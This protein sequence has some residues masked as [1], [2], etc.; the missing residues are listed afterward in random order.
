VSPQLAALV[1]RYVESADSA[2]GSPRKINVRA[3]CV[4]LGI[5]KSTF[6]KYVER[7][8]AEGI[9]GFFPR[10]RRPLTSPDRLLEACED[11]LVR[12]R[13]ELLD[14]GWDAGADQIRFRLIAQ[15]QAG[16]CGW[17][18]SQPVPSRATINRVLDRRGQLVKVPKRRPRAAT[19]R[20]EAA[21]P[22]QRWQMDGFEWRLAGGRSVVILHIIDDCSRFEI[23]LQVMTSE[24]AA[25]VWDVVT[26][27]A[28]RHGLPAQLLTDNGTAFSG[29]RRGWTSPLEAN[30]AALGVDH[31]T[32]SIAH[33]QTCGK[34]ERAHQPVQR[35]LEQHGPFDTVAEL[36]AA[37]DT[38]RGRFNHDRPKTHLGGLTPAQRYALGEK[39][40]PAGAREQPLHVTRGKVTAN[41]TVTIHRTRVGIGRAH[42]G[43]TVTLFRRADRVTVFDANTL[44]VEFDLTSRA[45][46]QSANPSTTKVSAKS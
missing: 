1:A 43:K 29:H 14:E 34:V 5:S 3:E 39:A 33:P 25:E 21:Q 6:Y 28:D 9:D 44:V 17:P 18:A 30:M 23:A 46:Y 38:Y 35:W 40:A 19:R 31:F 15:I 45:G 16:E 12:A 11:E 26:D 2:A 13:K 37:L 36:Q 7:F 32:S 8:R 24:N 42:A 41:G 4:A 27:A 10:S 20:F 22:N